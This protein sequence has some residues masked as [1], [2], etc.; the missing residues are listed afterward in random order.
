[1]P[2]NISAPRSTALYF[3][4]DWRVGSGLT[5][6]AGV[7]WE[8]GSPIT[9]LYGRLVNLDIANGF[10][11]EAP[12]VA[13]NPTGPLTGRAYPDSLIDPDQHGIQ[14]RVGIAWRPL[15][16][17]SLVIRAG[18]GIYYDTSVYQP[19][20]TRWRSSRRFRRA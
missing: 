16:A 6:N 12:V 8:Y 13:M 9:E 15:L 18:Y 11:A 14:P 2:T 3:T 19:I 4:D 10:A 5:V 1:M 20:A 7:R 17:S